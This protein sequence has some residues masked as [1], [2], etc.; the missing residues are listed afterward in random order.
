MNFLGIG[1]LELLVIAVLAYFLLGPKKMADAGKLLGNALRELRRQRDDFTSMLMQETGEN[2][3]GSVDPP[4][5]DGAVARASTRAESG[6]EPSDEQ[7]SPQNRGGA[8]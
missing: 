5:P 6:A 1:G 2:E 8:G 4:R 3:R 7:D